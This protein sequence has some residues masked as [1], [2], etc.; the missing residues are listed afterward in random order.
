M[1]FN[2]RRPPGI[3]KEEY[4][5]EIFQRYGDISDAPAVPARPDWCFEG[6]LLTLRQDNENAKNIYFVG[7]TFFCLNY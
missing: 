5:T 6:M 1:E 3:Y 4:I 2:S 7:F